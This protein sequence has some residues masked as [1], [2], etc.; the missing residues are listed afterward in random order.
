MWAKKAEKHGRL[1]WLP[2]LQHLE[3]VKTVSLHLWEDWL[4]PRQR[5]IVEEAL[6]ATKHGKAKE[7]ISFIALVHDIGKATP[8]FSLKSNFS[9]PDL[10]EVLIER[11]ERGGFHG[12]GTCHLLSANNSHHTI[13]GQYLLHMFGVNDDIS[14]IIGAHHGKPVDQIYCSGIEGEDDYLVW[15]C[16]LS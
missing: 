7:L 15:N 5:S 12:L 13:A 9:S 11:M 3:D 1:M 8:V 10:D 16:T 14:V 6:D 4:S 2:L